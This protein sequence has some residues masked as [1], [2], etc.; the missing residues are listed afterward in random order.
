MVI[1]PLNDLQ[2]VYAKDFEHHN[3]VLAVRSMMDERVKK[4]YTVR[5][6]TTHTVLVQGIHE[7]LVLFVVSIH[8]VL[9][10]ISIPVQSN[11]IEDLNLVVCCL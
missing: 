4:L 8:R 3:K 5:G 2:K 11:F 6:I 7:V 1:V 9:P 10:A